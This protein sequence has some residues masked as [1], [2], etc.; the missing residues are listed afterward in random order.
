MG[1]FN[2]SKIFNSSGFTLVEILV[3]ILILAVLFVIAIV[4]I[5]PIKQIGKVRDA[6]R[7]NDLKQISTALDAFY[8]DN[9]SYPIDIG[10]LDDA[11]KYIQSIPIDPVNADTTNYLYVS[12]NSDSLPQWYVLFAS[13]ENKDSSK[14][15]CSLEKI[16]ANDACLPQGI[17]DVNA[18]LIY[19]YCVV[20]GD[21]DCSYI[22]SISL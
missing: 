19:N 16:K 2:L 13:L 12:D 18:D 3:V 9:T 7:Q 8:N 6:Q 1:K 20:A 22:N 17:R 10:E 15:L 11:S 5:D 14:S 4:A 21:V